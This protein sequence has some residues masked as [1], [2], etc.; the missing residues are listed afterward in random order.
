MRRRHQKRCRKPHE[1]LIGNVKWVMRMTGI[2]CNSLSFNLRKQNKCNLR[3]G[4]F[5]LRLVKANNRVIKYWNQLPLRVRNSTS[6]NA[7]KAGLDLF[8][9]SKPDSPD[10]FWKLSEEIFNRIS[11]K[12]E[13]LNY[14]LANR[15]F[16]FVN[17]I[18]FYF[19]SHESKIWQ[20]SSRGRE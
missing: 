6:I 2:S 16:F 5:S 19:L 11:D 3:W 12:S 13:H 14:L 20:C 17:G 18:D 10:T 4:S 8:K 7:V 15:D 1:T 9:L